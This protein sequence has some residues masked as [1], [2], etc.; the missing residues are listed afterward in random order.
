MLNNIENIKGGFDAWKG[1]GYPV[2]K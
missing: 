2:E 1:A